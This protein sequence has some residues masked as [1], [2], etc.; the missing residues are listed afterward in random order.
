MVD[1]LLT[2]L[3]L[4]SGI[5]ANKYVLAFM[6]P[7]LLVAI[8]MGVSG[9]LIVLYSKHTSSRLQWNY[10][11]HD[12]RIISFIVLCTTLLPALLKAYALKTMLPSKQTLLGSV[13]P[14]ITALYAYILT[15]E[16]IGW[17][18]LSGMVI[19]FVGIGIVLVGST[20][21]ER[22]WGEWLTIS[23]P[24]CAV[25]LAVALG[26][27]GWILSQNMIRQERY[28]PHEITSMAMLASG[29]IS[30]ILSIIQGAFIHV[31]EV[32]AWKFISALLY[33]TLVGNIIGYTAYGHCLRRHSATFI[34]MTGLSMPL[35]VV[36]LGVA[37]GLDVLTWQFML[38]MV[39]VSC[40]MALFYSEHRAHSRQHSV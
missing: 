27:Y 13:D 37:L 12:I 36:G 35:M 1:M 34:A 30:L 31:P 16:R 38:A 22:V 19:G 10:I 15:G 25:L 29:V 3:V 23:L 7:P 5:V 11:R 9:L 17:R 2:Y 14:F 8:R 32:G 33:T 6:S 21:S 39:F 4:A 24:E 28:R 18:K 20:A 26:R 40:G